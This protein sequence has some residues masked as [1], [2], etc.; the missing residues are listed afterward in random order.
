MRFVSFIET[1]GKS[2]F[3]IDPERGLAVLPQLD[4]ASKKPLIGVSFIVCEVIGRIGV[5]GD[6]KAVAAKLRGVEMLPRVTA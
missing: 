4:A 2:E 3:Y 1:E 6:V 5:V